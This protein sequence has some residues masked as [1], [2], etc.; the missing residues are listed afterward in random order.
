MMLKLWSSHCSGKEFNSSFLAFELSGSQNN[1]TNGKGLCEGGAKKFKTFYKHEPE[2]KL[3]PFFKITKKIKNGKVFCGEKCENLQRK[4]HSPPLLQNRCCTMF[5]Y[6]SNSKGLYP[7]F[8][9]SLIAFLSLVSSEKV[10]PIF[11]NSYLALLLK[12]FQASDNCFFVTIFG[13][14]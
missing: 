10:V 7:I 1:S 8:S 14:L 2:Q 3:F 5:F 9:Y 4:R 6:S 11:S 13:F 12:F